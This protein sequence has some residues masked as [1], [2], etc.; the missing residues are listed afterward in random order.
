M[1]VKSVAFTQTSLN[2]LVINYLDEKTFVDDEIIQ[3]LLQCAVSTYFANVAGEAEGLTGV[4]TLVTSISSDVASTQMYL[5][6]YIILEVILY[7]LSSD[8][9]FR[10]VR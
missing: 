9:S 1:V 2:T 3:T 7:M 6:R 8:N 4:T 5:R 10:S